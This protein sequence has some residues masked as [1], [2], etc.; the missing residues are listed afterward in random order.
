[1]TILP[2]RVY[3]APAPRL[4]ARLPRPVRAT[5][6]A[7][8]QAAHRGTVLTDRA[9][10]YT[11]ISVGL[12]TRSDR[13]L[14]RLARHRDQ[15]VRLHLARQRSRTAAPGYQDVLLASDD[16]RVRL[17]MARSRYRLPGETLAVLATDEQ[18]AIR[19]A[20]AAYRFPLPAPVASALLHDHE[21]VRLRLAENPLTGTWVLTALCN[22]PSVTVRRAVMFH[23]NTPDECRV[24]IALALQVPP[25]R[26]GR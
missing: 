23:A 20:V 3:P 13:L 11:L 1:M 25:Q 2:H 4:A 21:I 12:L 6:A 17:Q 16:A 8:V 7:T 19:T 14:Q 18:V 22:D 24:E 9:A 26:P 5:V 15:T 10:A